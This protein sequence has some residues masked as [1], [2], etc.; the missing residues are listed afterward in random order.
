MESLS[1]MKSNLDEDGRMKD[2]TRSN[3]G[4]V[5]VDVDGSVSM[6]IL[7][8]FFLLLFGIIYLSHRIYIGK[9]YQNDKATR[10]NRKSMYAQRDDG[11]DFEA[12]DQESHPAD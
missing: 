1:L 11:E 2:M 10:E 3:T 7:M 12:L 5:Y 6:F 4:H 9:K 8:N